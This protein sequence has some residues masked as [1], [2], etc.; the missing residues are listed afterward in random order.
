MP[1]SN[2]SSSKPGTRLQTD[3]RLV[4]PAVQLRDDS[5]RHAKN[6]E[7][8]KNSWLE[9]ASP[10][11]NGRKEISELRAAERDKRKQNAD[12]KTSQQVF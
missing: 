3:A 8:S 11:S 2:R 5:N 9:K 6:M 10:K 1:K 4:V 7:E 12:F